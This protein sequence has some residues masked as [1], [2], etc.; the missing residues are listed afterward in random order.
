M[1]YFKFSS[2]INPA[3]FSSVL[4]P[5]EKDLFR[6]YHPGDNPQGILKGAG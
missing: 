1:A 4:D 2:L 6:L 5:A 3:P